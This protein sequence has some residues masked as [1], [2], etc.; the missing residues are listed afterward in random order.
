MCK[1]RSHQQ[2]NQLIY[3][4][5]PDRVTKRWKPVTRLQPSDTLI[6]TVPHP[7]REWRHHSGWNTRYNRFTTPPGR[8][9]WRGWQWA[10][11]MDACRLNRCGPGG[12]TGAGG[13]SGGL[14]LGEMLPYLEWEEWAGD[15]VCALVGAVTC[16]S[17]EAR[18]KAC[19]VLWSMHGRNFKPAEG[20]EKLSHIH[21]GKWYLSSPWK[22][23]R[24]TIW[25]HKQSRSFMWIC[26]FIRK[27]TNMPDSLT[28]LTFSVGLV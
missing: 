10:G 7:T 9:G 28:S 2:T 5:L 26:G 24:K 3:L 20:G 17:H 4:S 12:T 27:E 8:R 25:I 22:P 13:E 23:W 19:H 14:T 11:F 6:M 18:L 21:L 16:Q 15:N 1:Q